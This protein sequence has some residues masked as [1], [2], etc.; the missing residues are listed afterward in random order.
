TNFGTAH[1]WIVN[2]SGV[3]LGPNA[4]LDVG[5]PVTFT[6]ANYLRFDGATALFDMLST[7]ASLG[8]LSVAPVVAFGFLP[9][10][11]RVTPGTI[12]VAGSTLQVPEGHALSLVGG[13]ITIQGVTL[14]DG[15]IQAGTLRAPGG[16][17]NL[18]SVASPGEVLLPSFQTDSFTSMGTVTMKE[19]A[20]LD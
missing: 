9:L 18:V 12:S 3:M 8:P 5:G 15:T 14:E 16:Q 1:L 2:P 19:G 6:T 13:N 10:D 4:H 7:P 20:T 11:P 17:I